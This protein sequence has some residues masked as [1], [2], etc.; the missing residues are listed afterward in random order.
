MILRSR[1]TLH[2][3]CALHGRMI[4]YQRNAVLG[5]VL[6]PVLE[7]GEI[8]METHLTLALIKSWDQ[9]RKAF[10]IAGREVRFTV[11][12]VVIFTRN[13]EES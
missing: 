3:I 7:Y 9:R 12:D 5:I 2:S 4:P 8:A 10:R 13:R 11:F 1:C 6:G